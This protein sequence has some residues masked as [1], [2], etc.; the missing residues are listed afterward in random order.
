[1]DIGYA[2]PI[3][4]IDGAHLKG[5]YLGTIF[6]AVGIDGNNQILPISFCVGKTE[7]RESWIW[8]L[9]RLKECIRDMPFL[10][11]IA[12][13]S[14]S[15]EMAIQAGSR[16]HITNFVEAVKVY[17]EF[18]FK[19]S[20]SRLRRALN[21]NCHTW[22]DRIGNKRWAR[23]CFSW[24]V[25]VNALSRDPRKLPITVLIDFFRATMQQWWCHRY[26]ARELR[27]QHCS[28]WVSSYFT[29]ETHH[30]I[31]VEVVFLVPVQAKYEEPDE[32]MVVLSPLMDN[33]KSDDLKTITISHP[34]VKVRFRKNVAVAKGTITQEETM[35]LCFP[36]S[37]KSESSSRTNLCGKNNVPS[38]SRHTSQKGSQ[39]Y[40]T[41]DLKNS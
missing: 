13:R 32:V 27:Y 24:F 16:M 8:F 35:T 4:I 17:R 1:M 31:Y 2:R 3:L 25:F 28:A 5:K 11:I 7:S 39:Q 26:N 23:S 40:D 29:M 22:L 30:S 19:E 41:V 6:L 36:Q 33:D 18:D 21:D 37:K 38:K 20:L 12:D 10:A 9:S 34:K 15:I 14:N